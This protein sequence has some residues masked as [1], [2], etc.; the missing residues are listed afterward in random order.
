MK[1]AL[2]FG[3]SGLIGGHLLNQL[4][5]N[6]NY[7]K[8]KIFV[9]SEPEI[10]DPKV[11]I[12]KTDFNNL[13][14]HREVIKGDDCFFC[15]GTTKQNS[16]DKNDYRRVE[17]DVP[18]EIAQIAKSNSV[19]S[20]VF[21]SS[22]YADPKSSGDYLK[23]KGEVEEELKRLNFLKLGIM[24]PSFLLGDRKE[25]RVGEKIGIF[26]FKLLSPLFLGPLKKMKPIHSATVAK[27]MI[28][29]TQNES[30]QIIFESNEI[31]ELVLN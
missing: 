18:K 11:E 30:S 3:S 13:E 7:D 17:L 5:K 8:I 16:P 20:F 24:R 4:I 28:A 31:A 26:V 6:D 19:N 14:N 10:N 27:A 12:I 2:V 9:R 15:I 23:F 29:I 25:K 1:T 22:G 21:V